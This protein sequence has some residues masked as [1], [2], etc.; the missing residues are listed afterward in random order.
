M[1]IFK[2]ATNTII[3]AGV[4]VLVWGC[5]NPP[6]PSLESKITPENHAKASTQMKRAMH[7]MY[8]I[9]YNRYSSELERDDERRR[10]AMKLSQRVLLISEEIR[11]YP[12]QSG[13]S[14]FSDP[15]KRAAFMSLADR[16]RGHGEAIE[17]SASNYHFRI[18]GE[19]IK[20]MVQT[21]NRCHVQFSPLAPVIE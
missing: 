19:E 1:N 20:S 13:R 15:E 3:A 7:E 6:D 4:A 14:E 21:C 16:L 11:N 5:A 17:K 10:Y 9:L 2:I 8:T 12:I 18:L